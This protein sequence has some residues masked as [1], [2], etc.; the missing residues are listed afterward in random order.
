MMTACTADRRF[1][2]TTKLNDFGT[3][4]TAAWCSQNVD[5]IQ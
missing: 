1:M 3:R 4:Y 2:D 5:V